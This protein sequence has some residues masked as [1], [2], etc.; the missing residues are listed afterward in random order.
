MN[1]DN[2]REPAPEPPPGFWQQ[3]DVREA[4]RD[5][6]FGRVIRAYR[7]AVGLSQLDMAHVLG[8]SSQSDVS[9]IERGRSGSDLTRLQ[10]WAQ[11]L[12]APR[13]MLWFALGGSDHPGHA[14]EASLD[15]PAVSSLAVVPPETSGD[16]D[17]QRRDLFKVAAGAGGSG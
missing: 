12:G 7:R 4:L 1:R 14:R 2:G 13:D 15:R 8:V 16:G 17:V 6:A 11:V 3:E 10:E 9:R 5:R